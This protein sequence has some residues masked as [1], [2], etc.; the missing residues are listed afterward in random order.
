MVHY[1][2]TDQHLLLV[3]D[4]WGQSASTVSKLNFRISALVSIFGFCL[5]VV[6]V[7]IEFDFRVHSPFITIDPLNDIIM[8]DIANTSCPQGGH[9][10]LLEH[11]LKVGLWWP[12]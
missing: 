8:D 5:Y 9:S 3:V 10:R 6:Q 1:A 12:E 2:S 7:E 4:G 11:Y